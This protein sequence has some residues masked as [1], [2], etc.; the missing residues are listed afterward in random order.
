MPAVSLRASSKGVTVLMI[1]A[2][3]ILFGCVLT[4]LAA[5]GKVKAATAELER[6]E[7]EVSESRQIAQKLEKSKLDFL[8]ARSQVRCL[9]ASVSTQNYVPTMLKQIEHL[10][11]SVNLKVLGVRPAPPKVTNQPRSIKSGASASEGNVEAAS[12]PKDAA[13]EGDA[14]PPPAPYD[15]LKVD[16]EVEGRY[17]HTLDFLYKLTSFPKIIAVNSVDMSPASVTGTASPILNMKL[18]LTAY[19]LKDQAPARAGATAANG[20]TGCGLPKRP[21]ASGT[22]S[23]SGGRRANEAG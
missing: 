17:M 15:E 4:Y 18:N 7:K 19:V 6:K 13:A 2:A 16:I 12:K 10:G 8:D 14:A 3:L 20:R 21:P 11:R 9:E 1:V 22:L 23:S 5:A